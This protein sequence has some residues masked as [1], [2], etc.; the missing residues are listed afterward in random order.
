MKSSAAILGH[1]NDKLHWIGQEANC[2]A[3]TYNMILGW[4]CHHF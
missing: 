3:E 2:I 4:R 1:Y